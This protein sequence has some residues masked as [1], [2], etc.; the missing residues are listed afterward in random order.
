MEEYPLIMEFLFNHNIKKMVK[1]MD[2]EIYQPC[3]RGQTQA[4]S[5]LADLHLGAR[6]PWGCQ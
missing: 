6:A 4:R 5:I 3:L 2:K 1:I